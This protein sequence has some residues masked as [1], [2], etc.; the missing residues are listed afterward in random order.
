MTA[1][2]SNIIY[3]CEKCDRPNMHFYPFV[4]DKLK[5]IQKI[6][7]KQ[8]S[9]ISKRSNLSRFK[10]IGLTTNHIYKLAGVIWDDSIIDNITN[11]ISY[12]SDYFINLVL[13]TIIYDGHIL[14]PPI[15]LNEKEIE[16][17]SWVKLEYN[18]LI[19]I[20]GLF[21]QGSQPRYYL[22]QSDKFIYSEH[23]G[24]ISVVDGIV[25]NIIVSAQTKRTSIADSEI[26]LP[27]NSDMFKNHPYIFHTHPNTKTYA[28]R[29]DQGILY[30]LPS[31]SDILNFV[32][33]Y[34]YG[35]L[36][37]SIIFAPE[38]TYVLRIKKYVDKINIDN[39]IISSIK[40][41]IADI[42]LAAVE[43]YMKLFSENNENNENNENSKC[44]K[45]NN[46]EENTINN[47]NRL[48]YIFHK[49][50]ASDF[51]FIK[52]FNET[53]KPTMIYLEYYPRIEV[54]GEWM[55]RKLNLPY[56]KRNI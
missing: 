24:V 17:F 8:K 29:I 31:I 45:C 3:Y 16:N 50:V 5:S 12:P 21:N 26:Y 38:G 56:L 11:K 7:R 25:D 47:Q 46:N 55:F 52:K 42:E 43:K 49:N 53:L 35:N 44:S 6:C 37:A 32:K 13:N 4:I 1:S 48:A 39:S 14:N 34:N 15:Y 19:I 9:T 30:E 20:D 33:Y 54:N 23:S 36:Q 40:K 18:C 28:G 22:E 2:D 51:H 10:K 41:T 27:V